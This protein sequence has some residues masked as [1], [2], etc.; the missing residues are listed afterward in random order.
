MQLYFSLLPPRAYF[1]CLLTAQY[2][3]LTIFLS[4]FSNLSKPRFCQSCLVVQ[5]NNLLDTKIW[6]QTIIIIDKGQIS[7]MKQ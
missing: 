2:V 5:N 1:T 4:L 7:T 3:Q 6:Y